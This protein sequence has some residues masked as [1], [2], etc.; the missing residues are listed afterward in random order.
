MQVELLS[1]LNANSVDFGAVGHSTTNDSITAQDVSAALS[2]FDDFEFKVALWMGGD[3]SNLSSIRR[4]Y[5]LRMIKNDELM[6]SLKDCSFLDI[7]IA[8]NAILIKMTGEK[9]SDSSLARKVG[10]SAK[11]YSRKYSRI[12]KLIQPD[13]IKVEIMVLDARI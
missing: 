5:M 13:F 3:C 8:V 11:Q 2:H 10:V 7:K 12:V 9:H 4:D 6:E 1:K